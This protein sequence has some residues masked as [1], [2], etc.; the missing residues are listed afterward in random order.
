MRYS[1]TYLV[2]L[3][4]KA[5]NVTPGNLIH[6]ICHMV[7]DFVLSVSVLVFVY[8]YTSGTTYLCLLDS[9]QSHNTTRQAN[10]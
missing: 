2:F 9:P 3:T 7:L 1:A 8:A 5:L 4:P 10:G 6:G